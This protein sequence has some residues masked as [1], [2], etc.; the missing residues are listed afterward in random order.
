MTQSPLK[1][2]VYQAVPGFEDHLRLEL[3]AVHKAG[4]AEGR[5]EAPA[6]AWK[7]QWGA[8][9]YTEHTAGDIFWRQN[10]WL[11]P[12]L[13]EFDSISEA[14]SALRAIQRNWRPEFFTQFRRGALIAAKLPPISEKPRPF[15]WLLPGAPLGA[16]TLLDSRRMIASPKCTSPFPGGRIKF[17]EDREGPPSRAYLKLQEALVLREK[18]PGP[19]ERC[20]DAGASPGGWTWVLAR[21]GATVTAVDRAPLEPKILAMRGVNFLKHDAFTLRPE[22]L[23]PQD[24]VFSD[25]ICYPPRLYEWVNK[26]LA[27]G[28]CENFICTIKMQ[29]PDPDLETTRLFAAIPGSTV[30]HLWHNKHELTWIRTGKT[31]E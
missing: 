31:R 24:W 25:V 22:D 4:E 23:G 1:G 15:P 20:L 28:L 10:L 13:I 12:L 30:V 11:E 14:A 18:W 3:E 26:W 17:A 2:R 7:D 27:S 8:L 5:K 29:G 16:F 6:G 21:L 9:Y 19:G